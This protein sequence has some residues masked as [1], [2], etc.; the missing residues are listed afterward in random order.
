MIGKT[1]IEEDMATGKTWADP[2]LLP[3]LL[4]VDD[5]TLDA[6]YGHYQGCKKEEC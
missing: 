3:A 4:K 2:H 1:C 5:S 6:D